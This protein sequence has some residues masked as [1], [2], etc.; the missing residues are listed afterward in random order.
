MTYFIVK[1][2][3][4]KVGCSIIAPG[5]SDILDVFISKRD[6]RKTILLVIF[7]INCLIKKTV[8]AVALF[9]LGLRVGNN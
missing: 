8:P 2:Q 7:Q 5:H 3:Y 1:T 6:A 9:Y 4:Y